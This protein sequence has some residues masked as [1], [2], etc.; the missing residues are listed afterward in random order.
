VKTFTD[1]APAADGVVYQKRVAGPPYSAVYVAANGDATL[2]GIVRQLIGE[3]W[4]GAR[5][6]QY[7]G[8]IGPSR[9]SACITDEIGRI[10]SAL[11]RKF[12]LV[13]LF[14]VDLVIDGNYVWTI[15]VNPRY[16]ASGEVIERSTGEHSI[17]RHAVAC[18][19]GSQITC[20]SE[21][22]FNLH[23]KATLF[24]KRDLTI[25]SQLAEKLLVEAKQT[26]WPTLADIPSAE[27]LIE[28]GRPVLTVFGESGASE[29][30]LE[31]NL[32]SRV[33]NIERTLYP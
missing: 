26:P 18:A 27:T 7:C 5:E 25:D 15:E 29:Q 17:A 10:G 22:A 24:A 32:R 11:S 31:D 13:G 1:D 4:L 23:G 6:F 21:S 9:F 16:T 20:A 30:Q 14:G 2:L 3:P 19:D 12:N 33:A 8:A 28:R